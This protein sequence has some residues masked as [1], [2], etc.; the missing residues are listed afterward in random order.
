MSSLARTGLILAIASTVLAQDLPPFEAALYAMTDARRLDPC[1]YNPNA[2][3]SAV[4]TDP[5]YNTFNN[6]RSY[7]NGITFRR[8][9]LFLERTDDDKAR[10]FLDLIKAKLTGAPFGAIG[11]A[12]PVPVM[13]ASAPQPAPGKQNR[14]AIQLA[15]A[16]ATQPIPV[17]VP[18]APVRVAPELQSRYDAAFSQAAQTKAELAAFEARM[19]AQKLVL[20]RDI[21]DARARVDALLRNAADAIRNGDE[22]AAEENIRYAE[23]TLATIAKFLGK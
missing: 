6:R 19:A 9:E 4:L 13:P 18:P 1:T 8:F 11:P 7:N 2:D 17:P 21:S 3:H 12:A 22:A 20:R 14:P 15:P 23:G 5:A 10:C 16:P